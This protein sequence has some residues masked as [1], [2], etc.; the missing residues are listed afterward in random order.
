MKSVPVIVGVAGCLLAV[1]MVLSPVTLAALIVLALITGAASR[2]LAGVERRFVLYMLIVAIALRV[3]AIAVLFLSSDPNH[4]VSFPFDGDGLFIKLRSLWIRDVWLGV[5]INP[6][7]FSMAFGEYGW[8]S[9]IYLL[10]YLQYLL[11]P[12]PYAVHLVSVCFFVAA[13]VL[14]HR[15]ARMSF[16]PIPAAFA[17]V[18]TLSLP[19][20]FM[21]SI[22]AMKESWYLLLTTVTLVGF[23]RVVRGVGATSRFVALAAVV[24]SA[25]MLDTTRTGG[26]VILTVAFV[27]A[28][29]GTFLT[30]RL[31]VLVVALLLTVPVA[32]VVLE[33]PAVQERVMSQL[34]TFAHQHIGHV[35]T[36]GQGYKVLEERFY[37]GDSI[38]SMTWPEGRRFVRR[39]VI[40]FV[41]MPLPWQVVS[42]SEM[43]FIPEQLAWYGL[44]LLALIGVVRGCRGDV[45]ATWLFIGM[46]FAGAAAIAPNEGNVGTLV[47]HRDTIV[48]FVICLSALGAFS[49]LSR[50]GVFAGE[51][52]RGQ[53]VS[54]L[55]RRLD[56]IS[57]MWRDAAVFAAV[58]R[59]RALEPSRR[60][61][62]LG[63]MLLIGSLMAGVLA[64]FGDHAWPSVFPWMVVIA[65][66]LA[67]IVGSRTL[68]AAS[69]GEAATLEAD[70][71]FAVTT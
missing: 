69:Q 32:G 28:L 9:Y 30:R 22:S 25:M 65:V 53:I 54:A 14:L 37:S 52:G 6:N 50:A 4:L 31:H 44:V 11:G 5:S 26:L 38:E 36:D 47:R 68:A 51:G 57:R 56:V 27:L 17:F 48:P 13:A 10:A 45:F 35:R 24:V 12:A 63:T 43:L 64:P 29:V 66:A 58:E 2:G 21:W 34:R 70:E 55:L 67:M 8:T 16:G 39:A 15:F 1:A 33:Q 62:L 60:L 49:L 7:D 40:G 19:T 59:I 23:E 46:S 61:R 3:A 71:R 18:V 20:V 41:L 42:R